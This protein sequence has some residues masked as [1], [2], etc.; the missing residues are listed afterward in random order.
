MGSAVP[1]SNLQLVFSV[2]L[3]VVAGLI[4]AALGLGLLRSLV[5]G[6][7]RTI[8][9]LSLI[10]LALH[11]IFAI[12]NP[13]LIVAVIGLMVA[14]AAH[15]AVSRMPHV[16]FRPFGL[17]A[18]ALGSSTFI[19]GTIV[20]WLIIGAQPWY[21]GRVAIPIAGMI[22]GNTLN[23]VSLSL[24]RFFAD[25]RASAREIEQYLC[26]GFE[27]WE[28][29]RPYLRAAI[30][31]GMT[32]TINALMVVGLVSLPGMMTGQI[33]AGADPA[34]AIRYQIVVMLMLAASVSIGC[35]TLVGL[36]YRLCFGPDGALDPRI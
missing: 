18:L 21:T 17:A 24:D 12:D 2:G 30:R 31:A 26:L 28:A 35:L 6:T 5:W 9:Q 27:P 14:A 33:L 20:C 23:G 36:A 34:E 16:P 4:S 13:A 22:L 11:H 3:V 15:T 8:V 10:G 7:V 1:I 29:I 32:P 25:V 19:V